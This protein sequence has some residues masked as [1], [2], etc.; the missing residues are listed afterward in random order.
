MET[1]DPIGNDVDD[2]D[3]DEYDDDDDSHQIEKGEYDETLEKGKDDDEF[4]KIF[5]YDAK[6]KNG[7]SL[8][9]IRNEIES[10]KFYG[11]I[12][13][14][15]NEAQQ[16]STEKMVKSIEE[17]LE[18]NNDEFTRYPSDY[19]H[20]QMCKEVNSK[21]KLKK[22]QLADFN[23]EFVVHKIFNKY[24]GIIGEAKT[25]NVKA[26]RVPVYF[27]VLFLNKTRK[28]L[29]LATKSNQANIFKSH[30]SKYDALSS[31]IKGIICNKTVPQLCVVRKYI[32]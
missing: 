20:A 22:N 11:D 27:A 31:A 3:D 32:F 19:I 18:V 17:Q 28:Q 7:N 9:Q 10:E 14:P 25:I 2:D 4:S 16:N 1:S 15:Q 21:K 26:N 23:E 5:I 29:V 24:T 6:S 8:I 13:W 30:L 12:K